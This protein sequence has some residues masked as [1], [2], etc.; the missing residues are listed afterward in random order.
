M[1]KYQAI[2]RVAHD[3]RNLAEDSAR[4]ALD[5]VTGDLLE[6]AATGRFWDGR[7]EFTMTVQVPSLRNVSG[8]AIRIVLAAFAHAGWSVSVLRVDTWDVVEWD[9]AQGVSA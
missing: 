8:V 7:T 6:Y 3:G 2:V 9:Q 5:T 4:D 1:P